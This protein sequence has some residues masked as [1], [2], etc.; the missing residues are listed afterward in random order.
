MVT[1]GDRTKQRIL[2][3]ATNLFWQQSYH[4]LN[5]KAISD[6]AG[7]NKATIYGYFSSKEELAIAAI[8]SH[9]ADMK[10]CVL[11]ACLQQSGDPLEQLS[12]LYHHMYDSVKN[13]IDDHGIFPGCHFINMA[14]ELVTANPS[15]REAV[16]E[17]FTDQA[18]FY[19]Q[20]VLGAIEQNMP[21]ERL[22]PEQTVQRLLAMMN[23]CMVMAKVQNSPEVILSML[24]V[25]QRLIS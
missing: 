21:E 7:V 24:P 22:D 15:I 10:R 18:N 11:D 14:M 13:A 2:E 9:H 6:A 8:Q 25:A 23:G 5:M 12:A 17:V 16:Q 4:G 19:R 20:I 3:T 1:K